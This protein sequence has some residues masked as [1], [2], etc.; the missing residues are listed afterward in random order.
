MQHGLRAGQEIAIAVVNGDDQGPRRK[1][2]AVVIA[3][4]K[5]LERNRVVMTA[6]MLA[7]PFESTRVGAETVIHQDPHAVSGQP[8]EPGYDTQRMKRSLRYA[9]VHDS[10]STCIIYNT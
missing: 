7:L 8:S 9:L 6:D 2:L 4:R 10:F 1:R 5:I 3:C